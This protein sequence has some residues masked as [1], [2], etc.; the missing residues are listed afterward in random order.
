MRLVN[1]QV[2]KALIVFG[3]LSFS[4]VIFTVTAKEYPKINGKY[5]FNMHIFSNLQI[6][7]AKNSENCFSFPKNSPDY[8]KNIA[9]YYFWLFP[10]VMFN[11]YPWGLSINIVKPISITKT[12][13]SYLT[14]VWKED[15]MEA[16]A[17]GAL[18]R[19]EREDQGIVE[20]VQQGI[21]SRLYQHG[22]YS[23]SMEKG[24]HQFHQLLT[25][26]TTK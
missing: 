3:L 12:K 24:I 23:P 16:G 6:G 4:C 17:G 14:Y 22:R 13:I 1:R 8:G 21:Q 11:F 5:E 9:A 15:L 25:K 7:Y 26:F 10:N 18:D 19:V 2:N 20:S